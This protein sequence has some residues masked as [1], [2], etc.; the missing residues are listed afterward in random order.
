[1]VE[2]NQQPNFD[3]QVSVIGVNKHVLAAATSPEDNMLFQPTWATYAPSNPCFQVVAPWDIPVP[4]EHKQDAQ[5]WSKDRPVVT[6][7]FPTLNAI[8]S[9]R[10]LEITFSTD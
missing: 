6:G 7:P 5:Y 4:N 2:A 1:L 10:L 8:T 9:A 3:L